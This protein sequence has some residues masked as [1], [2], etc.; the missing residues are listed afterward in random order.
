MFKGI[1]LIIVVLVLGGLEASPEA[2]A[3]IASGDHTPVVAIGDTPR[4]VRVK[5]AAERVNH[6]IAKY[7]ALPSSGDA[8][9][10]LTIDHLSLLNDPSVVTLRNP[11][12]VA[13]PSV[14]MILASG[15]SKQAI[16]QSY[17]VYVPRSRLIIAHQSVSSS[18]N[19][20]RSGEVHEK[21]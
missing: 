15:P 8:Q 1:Q 14:N 6:C 2:N 17:H 12:E 13:D 20:K 7:I 4:L 9:E 21:L 19:G 18:V 16:S 3:R 5:F 11:F 10:G